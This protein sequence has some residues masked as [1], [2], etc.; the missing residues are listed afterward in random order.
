MIKAEWVYALSEASFGSCWEA[1]RKALIETFA[2]HKS[3][4]VQHTLYKMAESAL[5][6]CD[7]IREIHLSMP[8][9]HH[10]SFDLTRFGIE[11]HAE[12][13]VPTDKPYGL[14]E[15]TVRRS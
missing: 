7:Q 15:A 9:K 3:E 2:T 8:N 12:V 10:L 11:D 4:S 13:F 6:C 14:I 5:E 1:I